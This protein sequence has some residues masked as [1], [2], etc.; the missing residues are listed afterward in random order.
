MVVSSLLRKTD[1][2]HARIRKLGVLEERAQVVDERSKRRSTM[3]GKLARLSEE[4]HDSVMNS[5]YGQGWQ[6]IVRNLL[7][8]FA[9]AGARVLRGA[10]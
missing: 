10:P 6:M 9:W 3:T 5:D 7:C 4:S 1:T 2:V 8:T